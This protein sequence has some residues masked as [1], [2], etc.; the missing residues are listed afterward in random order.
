MHEDIFFH[1]NG[2]HV[3]VACSNAAISRDGVT[4][5]GVLIVRDVSERHRAE[6]HRQLLLA[7]LNHRVKNMLAVV[8]GIAEKSFKG[9]HVAHVRETFAARIRALGQAQDLLTEH[10]GI[11]VS[12]DRLIARAL[13]PF[14]E[15]DR[16][17]FEGTDVILPAKI[18][19][20]F[21]MAIHE[22]ATNALKYGALSSDEGS[23]A[24][25]WS[26][27]SEIEPPTLKFV[28]QEAGGPTIARPI[29]RGFGSQMIERVLSAEVSG[30]VKMEFPP[31]GLI[32][33]VTAPLPQA[34]V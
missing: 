22:L 23:I 24:I 17:R 13:S 6:K 34:F 31:T 28:W 26:L 32:C 5:G 18:A 16:V 8:Q 30:N 14:I 12:L 9:D 27:S 7:E 21:S 25:E 10:E 20:S 33:V 1:R 4:V 3:P 29:H 2:Q 19:A 11:A 15:A